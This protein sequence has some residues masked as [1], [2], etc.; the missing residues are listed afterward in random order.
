MF[1]N[2]FVYPYHLDTPLIQ[3]IRKDDIKQVKSLIAQGVDIHEKGGNNV[4]AFRWAAVNRHV[5]ILQVL[6]NAG[7][8]VNE[9]DVLAN[10]CTFGDVATVKCLLDNGANPNGYQRAKY[11]LTWAT[12]TN[13]HEIVN[14]LQ[15]ALGRAHPA[16][17]TVS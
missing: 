16:S 10:V 9:S 8:Y 5:D 12:L 4:T 6:I 7:A 3:A 1:I 11:S 2:K 14:L 17:N 15:E 13:H